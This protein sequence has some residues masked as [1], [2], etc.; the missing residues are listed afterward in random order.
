[1]RINKVYILLNVFLCLMIVKASAQSFKTDT[2]VLGNKQLLIN[3]PIKHKK[4][5][6]NYDEGI[7]I[8]YIFKNGAV[9]TLFNGSNQ[10]IPLLDK[11]RG[12]YPSNKKMVNN[13]SSI[14]GILEGKCWRED[15]CGCIRLFYKNVNP[16]ECHLFDYILDSISIQKE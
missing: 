16:T 12:Y 2:I 8:D 10:K 7:F 3:L 4:Y 6:T 9:V 1:M 13:R 14:I 15:S 5:V 11:E